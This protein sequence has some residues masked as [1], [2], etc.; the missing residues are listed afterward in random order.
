MEM[1]KP[2]ID[3][4][5]QVKRSVLPLA[6]G[7]SMLDLPIRLAAA[8]SWPWKNDERSSELICDPVSVDVSFL[9]VTIWKYNPPQEAVFS[10]ICTVQPPGWFITVMLIGFSRDMQRDDTEKRFLKYPSVGSGIFRP[11]PKNLYNMPFLWNHGGSQ[12]IYIT[13]RKSE[14][15]WFPVRL[16]DSAIWDDHET[17]M[18]R[19][20]DDHET[21][22]YQW[23][24][25]E[26]IHWKYL[27][28]T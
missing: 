7:R 2:T 10:F 17:T 4:P 25:Q 12:C 6:P 5:T 14:T 3:R 13:F 23:P 22:I 1:K 21:T 26:P 27:P 24:F 28:F 16:R 9:Q 20:W 15:R 8:V 18:R 19:P 11:L